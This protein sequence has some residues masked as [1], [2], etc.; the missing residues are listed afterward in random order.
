MS[1]FK[2]SDYNKINGPDI[3]P[4]FRVFW[5]FVKVVVFVGEFFTINPLI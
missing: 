1:V 2:L 3:Y 5:V 4:H